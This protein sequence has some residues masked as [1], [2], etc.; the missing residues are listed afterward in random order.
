MK[1]KRALFLIAALLSI[2][3]AS[4]SQ[5]LTFCEKVDASGKSVNENT[6]FTVTKNGGPVTMRFTLPA[7]Y[8]ATLVSF[9]VYKI[10]NGKEVFQTTLK[11]NVTNSQNWVSKQMTF[12][13]EGRYRVYVFDDQDKQLS[14]AEVLIKK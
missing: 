14:R 8:K 13:N 6:V 12:Y 4:F 5:A 11:Q 3:F 1:S 9:D 2:S 7:A 10:D